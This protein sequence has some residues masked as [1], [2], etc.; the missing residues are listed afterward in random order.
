M[1][2]LDNTF[3][4]VSD[5]DARCASRKHEGNVEYSGVRDVIRV[6]RVDS[7]GPHWVEVAL[8]ERKEFVMV[9]VPFFE[10]GGLILNLEL[11]QKGDRPLQCCFDNSNP[12]SSFND[13]VDQIRGHCGLNLLCL[14]RH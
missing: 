7:V 3:V 1:F 6:C 4:P 9:I 14:L 11:P 5:S 10:F 2:L 8:T 13:N 12:F